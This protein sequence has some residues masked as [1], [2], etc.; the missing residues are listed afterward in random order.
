MENQAGRKQHQGPMWSVEEA[1]PLQGRHVHFVGIGGIGMSAVAHMVL[2]REAVVSGSD[3]QDGP[4]T[5]SLADCGCQINIGHD[6]EHVRTAELVVRS[7]A[8]AETNPEVVAAFRKH[9]PVISRARM[10]ARLAGGYRIVAV[11]GA[12]GKT[13]TTWL[14]T[15]LLL[16]AHFDPTAMVGGIVPELGGNFRLGAGPFFVTEVDESDGSLL[17]FQPDY[18]IITNVDLEHVDRY[19]DLPAVQSIFRRYLRRTK[20]DGCVILCADSPAA[21]ELLAAWEG[22]YLTYGFGPDADYQATNIRRRGTTS[23]FDVRRPGDVLRSL[24]LGLPGEHNIANALAVVALA[25]ALGIPDESLRAALAHI[26]GVGRRIE[27]KGTEAGVT[28]YDD[29]A[30]HPTE[31]RATIE[32]LGEM[33]GR[34]LVAVFQPHRYSRTHHL[35]ESFGDCFDGLD[36]LV[37]VPI[38]AAGESPIEGASADRIADAVRQHGAVDCTSCADWDAARRRLLDVLAPGDTL[39]TLGAGDVHKLG[40][41]ILTD[42]QERQAQ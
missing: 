28:L 38:Y 41:Q 20:P 34:R 24:S 13:T 3:V 2:E 18:S 12:H 40:D 29:Y 19:P 39:V 10:L 33:V 15:K 30:H 26:Q 17:E 6:P 23:I 11:A 25:S 1:M 27:R 31:I 36:H 22:Q 37:L 9:I 16:D 8:I 21:V 5:R 7:S 32:A 4:I 42:L 35:A 14:A